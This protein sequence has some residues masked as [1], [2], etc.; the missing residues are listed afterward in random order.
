M[1]VRTAKFG[2]CVGIERAYNLMNQQASRAEGKPI[3][4]THDAQQ[5]NP[6]ID[7]DTLGRIARGDGRLLE[8]Y[9]A[10]KAVKVLHDPAILRGDDTLLLGFHGLPRD[11]VE[12][13]TGKGIE[14]KDYKCPFIATLDH[15]VDRVV[16]EGCD[17]L[18]VGTRQ[19]H[20]S[21]SAQEAAS[22]HQRQCIVIETLE[23]VETIP[24]ETASPW[25]LV[26]VVTANTRLWQAVVERVHQRGLAV[27]VLETICPDTYQRQEGAMEL[28]QWA[29]CC[30][31]VDDGGGASQSLFEVVSAV[32]DKVYRC[33]WRDDGSWKASL[34]VTW[35]T[36]AGRVAVVGGI[37]VP[38]WTIDEVAAYVG[39]LA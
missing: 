10:L 4:A 39:G 1:E 21:R 19:N 33:R 27:H 5:P 13:L 29:D 38:K 26:G 36:G 22:R 20:H 25:A 37:L 3:Y 32:H 7:M 15:T 2:F 12:D 30:L 28:A 34:D 11:T 16:A 6:N 35:V 31:V 23:D 17:L 18:I 8:R 24:L 14:V 9:P